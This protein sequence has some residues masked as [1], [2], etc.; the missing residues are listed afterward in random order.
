FLG[1][2]RNRLLASTFGASA[3]LDAYFA[4][5][6]LPDFIYNILIAGGIV[7]AFLPLFGEYFKENKEKAWG[8][9]NNVLD[10]FLVLLISISIIFFIITPFLVDLI[11]PGFEG[12]QRS[13][14][15]L[16]TRIMFLSPILLGLS[17][18]FSGIVQYFDRFLVYSL[19]PIFYNLG[20][21]IGIIFLSPK[22]GILGVSFGVIL[23]ALLHF[24]IKIPAAF[25]CGFNFEWK[26]NFKSRRIKKL[27]YLM[28]PRTIGVAA[29]QIN[30]LVMTAIASILATGSVSIFNFA[31]HLYSF[32]IGIAGVSF[33]ISAFPTLSKTFIKEKEEEFKIL[34]INTFKKVFFLAV[35]AVFILFGLRNNIVSVVLKTGEFTVEASKLTS[36]TFGILSLALFGAALVPLLFRA[37]FALKDTFTPT[38]ITIS[39]V[40]L[41]VILAFTFIKLINNYSILNNWIRNLFQLKEIEDISILGLAIA[42]FLTIYFKFFLLLFFLKRK[43]NYK[44]DFDFVKIL[45]A[46]LISVFGLIIAFKFTGTFKELI[47]GILFYSL[48][49]FGLTILF[50]LKE[51]KKIIYFL[52]NKLIKNGKN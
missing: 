49:Y 9:V 31:K 4:A 28:I 41:N 19:C 12:A 17:S 27:F 40:I 5:F 38:L 3:E 48:L 52:N 43:I 51:P 46:G 8:F 35:P 34:F 13:L 29:E 33:A 14:T 45:G 15:I 36:A 16:L 22:F 6:R 23:G 20:I 1:I 25:S 39:I 26:L 21:I 32:P 24:L 11:A 50:G 2:F 30:I 47:F 44:F 10:V 18:V 37:F 7:V 42:F